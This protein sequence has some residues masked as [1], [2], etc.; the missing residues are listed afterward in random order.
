MTRTSTTRSSLHNSD[1][2]ADIFVTHRIDNY[3]LD[4][5]GANPCSK[6]AIQSGS[7]EKPNV[8]SNLGEKGKIRKYNEYLKPECWNHFI[9]FAF[10]YT[11]RLGVKATQ[12]INELCKLD[13]LDLASS[14]SVKWNRIKFVEEMNCIMARTNAKVLSECRTKG[15]A[16]GLY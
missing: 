7:S 2:R 5:T 13:N 8:A 12:F 15:N 14:E 3:F 1:L 4:L 9:P 10:E 11:C 6:S 16:L